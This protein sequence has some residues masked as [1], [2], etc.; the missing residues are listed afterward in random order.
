VSGTR[1]NWSQFSEIGFASLHVFLM[2]TQNFPSI[3]T[4]TR[5]L[6]MGISD[7]QMDL[8][9]LLDHSRLK[10]KDFLSIQRR[11]NPILAIWKL[12]KM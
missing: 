8:S 10:F 3:F 1:F 6:R 11:Y 9:R 4:F 7:F 12:G 5:I 2:G